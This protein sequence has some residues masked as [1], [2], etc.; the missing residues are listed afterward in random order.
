MK[1][2]I[3]E[4][5]SQKLAK[6]ALARGH[7]ASHI[8]WLKK[9]G[10]KDWNLKAVIL[11]GDWTF[12]TK[13]SAD[14]RGPEAAPGATGQYAGVEIH[15]GLICLNGPVGMDLDLQLELFEVA[16]DE[17][18]DAPDLVNQVLEI[19]AFGDEEIAVL[20]YALPPSS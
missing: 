14:F 7:E 4:C 18:A 10:W 17:L 11:E 20:R 8:V 12:V 6:I 15:A 5:L 9:S 1:F 13:N 2:L 19:S 3:D 16:L